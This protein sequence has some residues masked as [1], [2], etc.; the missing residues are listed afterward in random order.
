[1]R[2]AKTK[3]GNGAKKQKIQREDF[4]VVLGR[5]NI[6]DMRRFSERE[7]LGCFF[8]CFSGDQDQ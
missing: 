7:N 6:F 1:M 8:D 3:V 4:L 5:G 2:C